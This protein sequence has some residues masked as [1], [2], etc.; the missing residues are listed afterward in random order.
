[1]VFYPFIGC[2]VC[3]YWWV[4]RCV[5]VCDILNGACGILA[6]Q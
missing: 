4:Y 6:C 1:M 3:G 2:G 5:C